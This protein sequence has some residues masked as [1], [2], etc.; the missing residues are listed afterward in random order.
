MTGEISERVEIS[1]PVTDSGAADVSSPLSTEE[2]G[3]I[4]RM[5]YNTAIGRALIKPFLLPG[6]SVFAGYLLSSCV[7]K[8]LIPCFIKKNRLDMSLYEKESYNSFNDFFA[9]RIRPECRPIDFNPTHL[10]S[11]CDSRLSVYTITEDGV[12]TI[13]HTRYTVSSLLKNFDLAKEY[14]GGYIL[15]FRLTVSDYHRYCFPVDGTVGDETVIAGK[16]HT[17][18]P[19]SNDRYPVYKENSRE[20]CTINND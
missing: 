13:K 11:P 5:L 3:I 4:L 1:D 18:Q 8:V 9:R 6:F 15:I 16:L 14:D 2:S 7:S 12:F 20:Y 19:I 17:V 10:I